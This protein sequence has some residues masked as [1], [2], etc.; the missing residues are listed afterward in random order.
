M[1]ESLPGFDRGRLERSPNTCYAL[2]SRLAISYYNPAYLRFA[3]ENGG[4]DFEARF[5]IGTFIGVAIS[6]PLHD[7]YLRLFEGLIG[8]GDV[9]AHDYECSSPDRLRKF[10]MHVYPLRDNRGLLIE[11]SLLIEEPHERVAAPFREDDY[12]DVEG[13]IHMCGHCRR[14]QNIRTGAWDWVPSAL[15]HRQTS[16]GLC[17][18]CMDYYYPNL[19]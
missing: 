9:T 12:L 13:L 17:D 4:A 7:Y 6:G 14:V 15:A 2:D 19:G 16:H 5:G 11:H 3:K 8:A 18:P 1:V 10:R